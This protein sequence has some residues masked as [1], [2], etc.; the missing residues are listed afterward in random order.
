MQPSTS[1]FS[2]YDTFQK[3][4][5]KPE[6][7]VKRYSTDLGVE[8]A[9]SRVKSA[10]S[11]I[12]STEDTIAATPDSVSGRTSGSLVTDSQRNRLVQNEVAPMNEVLRTQGNNYS[13]ASGD[14][15]TLNTDLNRKVDLSLNADDTQANTLMQLYAAAL[16]SEKAAEAKR[17]FEEG[18][19]LEREKMAA[20]ERASR[21]AYA[22]PSFGGG[23]TGATP[24]AAMV[25]KS[26]GGGFAF[27]DADGNSI[28]A[29][30]YASLSG[31]DIRDVLYTMGQQG[32][33]YAAQVYNQLRNDPFFGKGDTN[34]DTRV[35]STYSPLFW[36]TYTAQPQPAAPKPA[37][38]PAVKT[39]A[40]NFV[41]K[42]GAGN[43]S[44]G[45]AR[46]NLK[47]WFGI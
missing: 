35:K 46:N 13:E 20:S 27:A 38:A 4:R 30:Q 10:R 19:R 7:Y 40:A 33:N 22:T 28:S 36:G 39:Q 47:A 44:T 37:P 43:L 12:K 5:V 31:K 9:K 29:A 8:D 3:S 14:L 6:D 11:A 24:A 32:D 16:E 23:T 1:L 26:N 17:Q 42:P 15:N 18:L 21:A 45:N 2:Q 41:T 34:Y 25:K